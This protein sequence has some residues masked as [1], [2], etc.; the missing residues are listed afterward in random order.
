MN[1]KEVYTEEVIMAN[2]FLLRIAPSL[3]GYTYFKEAIRMILQD[4]RYRINVHR[5]LF[6][7]VAKKYGT[8][9]YIVDRALR[10]AIETGY[11]RGGM[12][13]FVRV[14]KM[15]FSNSKPCPREILLLVADNIKFQIDRFDSS[16]KDSWEE[17]F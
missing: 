3:K 2:L 1:A 17:L 8:Q 16:A 12:R 9:A 10:N 5:L 6:A 7:E 4:G 11:Q 14:T 15:H 13:E